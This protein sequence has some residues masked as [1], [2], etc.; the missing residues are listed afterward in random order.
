[1]KSEIS[2]KKADQV[3]LV[4]KEKKSYALKKCSFGCLDGYHALNITNGC[5]HYCVYCYA[6]GYSSAPPKGIVELYVNLPDLIKKELSNPRK[7]SRPDLVIFNTSTDCF[8]PHPE[9]LNTTF[10]CMEEIL[11]RNIT[12][13]F[14]TKGYIPEYFIDLFSKKRDF[15]RAQIGLI[16]LNQELVSKFEPFAPSVEERLYNIERLVSVGIIPDVRLDPIIPFL[17][18]TEE[19]IESL[20]RRLKKTGIKRVTLSYLH[21]RP[22]IFEIL[23]N[24]L[25]PSLLK[26]LD[27]CY[28]NRPWQKVGTST[29][30]KLLPVGIRKKGYQRIS[31]IAES[32]GI[33]ATVCYCKNPDI[34]GSFCISYRKPERAP[35]QLMLPF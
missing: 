28:S 21:I 19:C 30:S 16:S 27:S 22:A 35:Q 34:K 18:D 20:F 2:S 1:M 13:S 32:F 7:R 14:L 12:I 10:K 11:K 15:V 4:K 31:K 25:D 5:M 26:L 9:I 8:Q 24:E 6:R 3:I 23:R 33:K 29:M 17:T